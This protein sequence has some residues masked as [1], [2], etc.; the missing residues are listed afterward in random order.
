M[1]F[2]MFSIYDRVANSYGAPQL[3]QNEAAAKRAF[4]AS[5]SKSPFAQDFDLFVVGEFNVET[6]EV[7]V[8][9]KPVFLM[10]FED[11]S[12]QVGE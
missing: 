8:P 4:L 9:D 3:A 6:G 5:A 7:S 12:Q 10:H 1:N 2:V 11:N